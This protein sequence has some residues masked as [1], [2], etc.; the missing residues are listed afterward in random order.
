VN[1]KVQTEYVD[2]SAHWEAAGATLISAIQDESDHRFWNLTLQLVANR[3]ATDAYDSLT[4]V[5]DD[6]RRGTFSR[7]APL[8]PANPIPPEMTDPK[9]SENETTV[10]DVGTNQN[11][12]AP[13]QPVP[14]Q[15]DANLDDDEDAAARQAAGDQA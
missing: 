8:T 12:P 3:T 9:G 13:N 1:L 6:G 4:V 7:N 14:N 2:S 15:S 10:Q 5:N 11:Q